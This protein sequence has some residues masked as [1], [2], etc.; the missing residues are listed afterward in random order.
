LG[1]AST[2]EGEC[3]VTMG[4]LSNEVGKKSS[5]KSMG[6][7]GVTVL[8]PLQRIMNPPKNTAVQG[9]IEGG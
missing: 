3:N 7:F 1:R 6:D 8:Q 2:S 5:M 4:G 9:Y